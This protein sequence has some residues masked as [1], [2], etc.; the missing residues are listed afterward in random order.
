MVTSK[1]SLVALTSSLVDVC[2]Q[3]KLTAWI[4]VVHGDWQ[5]SLIGDPD[6]AKGHSGGELAELCQKLDS[7]AFLVWFHSVL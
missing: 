3:Y 2:L 1:M 5:S 7:W 4:G 6:G